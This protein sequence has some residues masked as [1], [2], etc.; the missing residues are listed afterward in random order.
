[1]KFLLYDIPSKSEIQLNTGI[2]Y[3]VRTSCSING[4]AIVPFVSHQAKQ[5]HSSRANQHNGISVRSVT[6]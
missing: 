2:Q 4:F 5:N 3:L 6:H 1:M